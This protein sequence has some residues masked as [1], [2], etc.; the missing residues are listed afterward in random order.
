MVS[1]AADAPRET[2]HAGFFSQALR[3]GIVGVGGA[4]VDYSS[5]QLILVL[6]VVPELARVLS[7]IIGS[8]A[9]YLVNR[10]WTFTSRR[11][12]REVITL[13]IVLAVTFALVGVVNALSLHLLP[14]SVWRIT[15]A[16]AISQAVGT[17]FNFLAQ[18]TFVFRG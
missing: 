15:L 18:R 7:F 2:N 13:A 8:T 6:G 12:S 14:E 9:V 17:A 3:F 16:W 11:N 10:R 1:N 4:V 5:L